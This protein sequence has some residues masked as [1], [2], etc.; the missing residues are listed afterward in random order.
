[1]EEEAPLAKKARKVSVAKG[2]AT[3]KK[4]NWGGA[5]DCS[6]AWVP[7]NPKRQQTKS[8]A[9]W[10]AYAKSLTVQEA[11]DLGAKIKDLDYDY[12]HGFVKC[13]KVQPLVPSLPLAESCDSVSPEH[14]PLPLA[15]GPAPDLAGHG[16]AIAVEDK[17]TMTDPT[18][19]DHE[20][21]EGLS[22]RR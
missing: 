22:W 12:H 7:H 15:A 13:D 5:L 9:R 2:A 3:P 18:W 17:S 4:M 14:E 6:I 20:V 11:L 10:D 16:R 19:L 1:M 21:G 8:A